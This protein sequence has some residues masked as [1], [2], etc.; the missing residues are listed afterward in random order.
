MGDNFPHPW[1]CVC[2]LASKLKK[3][4]VSPPPPG[5]VWEH[6]IYLKSKNL[7]FLLNSS[8][9][10]IQDRNHVRFIFVFPN[11]C[12]NKRN[13][14]IKF[15]F[16][17]GN[18]CCRNQVLILQTINRISNKKA[19]PFVEIVHTSISG[20]DYQRVFHFINVMYLYLG[21]DR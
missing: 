16:K 14:V 19:F 3:Q 20:N 10:S 13:H 4:I 11:L 5:K 6:K 15:N 17:I 12:K 8:S 1:S 9:I 18:F 21:M 7:F 2:G